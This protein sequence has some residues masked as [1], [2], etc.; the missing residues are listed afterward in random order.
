M[1]KR[2]H[3]TYAGYLVFLGLFDIYCLWTKSCSVFRRGPTLVVDGQPPQLQHLEE[4]P[5]SSSPQN[6]NELSLVVSFW[7][8]N[9]TE[10]S[11][12]HAHR[13]EVEAAMLTNLQNP[14]LDQ[15]VV[16]LDSVSEGTTT[17]CQ[18]FIDYMTQ[19]L[20]NITQTTPSSSASTLSG[21]KEEEDLPKLACIERE[22]GQPNY[23]D[24]FHYAIYH[25]SITSSV[26]IVSNA[27]QV[28]DETLVHA[29]SMNE[30]TIF[31]LSTHG[32]EAD[33]VPD[34]VR[35]QYLSL[36]GND[37]SDKPKNKGKYAPMRNRCVDSMMV[38]RP[39]I[40]YSDSWDTYIFPRSLLKQTLSMKNSTTTTSA[41]TRKNFHRQDEI[42][43]MNQLG[44]EYVALYDITKDLISN[45]TV[46]NACQLIRTWHF[47]LAPKMHHTGDARHWPIHSG[48]LGGGYI[49]YEDY[50]LEVPHNPGKLDAHFKMPNTPWAILPPPYAFVPMCL[51]IK[52][53]HSDNRQSGIFF[54]SQPHEDAVVARAKKQ[55]EAANKKAAATA[56]AQAKRI[57]Q[58]KK[59]VEKKEKIRILPTKVTRS[60]EPFDFGTM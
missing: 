33:R 23:Y 44:A 25:P 15:L 39:E 45:V 19:R 10:Q 41:F 32:Y 3:L 6:Q 50:G 16:I 37:G 2:S 20:Q 56:R 57:G 27:D 1:V 4:F 21:K 26:V 55:E 13:R 31:V 58:V 28:F 49:Y 43:Y 9:E 51:G 38:G 11:K 35:N 47:H 60:T 22:L 59:I 54:H 30:D 8:E 24:L 42:Y 46:W 18:S 36:V 40:Q 17:T 34:S 29:K 12:P 14:N 5:S 7:A 53:C 48:G 52:E